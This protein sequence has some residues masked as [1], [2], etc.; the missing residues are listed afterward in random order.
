MLGEQDDDEE[1]LN[2]EAGHRKGDDRS[3]LAVFLRE[4][5]REH[6]LL[7][8]LVR[9]FRRDDGVAQHSAQKRQG[10]AQVHERSAPR[11]NN[12]LE[13]ACHRRVGK[14]RELSARHNAH[15][16]NGNQQIDAQDANERGNGC[17]AYVFAIFRTTGNGDSTLDAQEDPD[18]HAHGA[19]NLIPQA[20]SIR[21]AP[22]VVHEDFRIEVHAE[23]DGDN[24]DEQ[25]NQLG[26]SRDD[27]DARSLFHA[28][29]HQKP[30]NPN[31]DG[32]ANDRRKVIAFA[33]QRHEIRDGR[34]QKR[35][36]RNR[37][38]QRRNPVAIG[39]NEAHELAP[40]GASIRIDAAHQFRFIFAQRVEAHH[41]RENANAAY[42]P[43]DEHGTR[44][45]ARRG[46]VAGHGEDAT[47]DDGGNHGRNKMRQRQAI[48]IV[49]L[50]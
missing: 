38:E 4:D 2:D 5:F 42:N 44:I 50:R 36:V 15:G 47:A 37:G 11:T 26:D 7:R 28:A 13:H 46:H 29:A 49:H 32:C 10:N 41:E 45:R 9:A 22:E 31:H 16:Q 17:A 27:V 34:E 30:A 24:R 18:A 14:F 23:Q 21:L 39:R 25:R 1:R 33:K 20:R 6:A 12:G 43:A 3:A 8:S 40:T 35:G 19:N 48:G